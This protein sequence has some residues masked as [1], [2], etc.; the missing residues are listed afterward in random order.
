MTTDEVLRANAR[1]YEAFA[2]GDARAMDELWARDAP[3][4]C[5]HP[6]WRII[7]ERTI[8]MNSWRMILGEGPTPISCERPRVLSVDDSSAVVLCVEHLGDSELT[9]TNVFTRER[10]E[11]RMVHHHAG[12]IVAR[13]SARR[14]LN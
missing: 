13:P 8:V 10:G 6:G 2:R 14:V 1:F 7:D 4:A 12:P 3:V 11:W 5:V 9:A